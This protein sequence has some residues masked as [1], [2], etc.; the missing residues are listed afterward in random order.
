M[1]NQDPP[2]SIERRPQHWGVRLGI[3]SVLDSGVQS[4]TLV[5]PQQ[6]TRNLITELEFKSRC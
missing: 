5:E 2:A 4:M 3:G 1:S 6:C